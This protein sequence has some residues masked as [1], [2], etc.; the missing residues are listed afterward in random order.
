MAE[1]LYDNCTSF[2]HSGIHESLPNPAL[3]GGHVITILIE[4]IT[5]KPLDPK[6]LKSS[7]Y[8]MV[9]VFG[10]IFSPTSMISFKAGFK[11]GGIQSLQE[12]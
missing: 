11:T 4:I 8:R 7:D 2:S 6:H 1:F 3:D 12:R 10:L 5:G 9:I